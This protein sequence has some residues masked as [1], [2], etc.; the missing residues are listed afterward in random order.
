MKAIGAWIGIVIGAV[1]LCAGFA[2]A[3]YETPL[4]L[5]EHDKQIKALQDVDNTTARELREQRDL[6]LEIRGDIK[7]LNRRDPANK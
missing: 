1:T 6:L 4:K 5:G 3:Y 2:K 7:H